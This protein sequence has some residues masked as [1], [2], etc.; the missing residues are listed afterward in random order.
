VWKPCVDE[1]GGDSEAIYPMCGF[2]WS[3]SFVEPH[4]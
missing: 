3:R 2:V 4:T 1:R